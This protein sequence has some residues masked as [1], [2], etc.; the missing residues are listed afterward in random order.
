MTDRANT[1][2]LLQILREYSDPEHIL[3]MGE[4]IAKLRTTYDINIDRRTVYSS[5][6]LLQTLGYDISTYA[7]NGRGYFLRTREFEPSEIQLLIDAVCS[8]PFISA[9]QSEQLLQKLQNFRS[10][11]ERRNI[12]N[13]TAIRHT[14]KTENRQVFLNIEL[15]D[16]AIE[17]QQ[18]VSFTYLTY[19]AEKQLIPR[20]QSPYVVTPYGM[21]YTNAH[22][23]LAC[24]LDGYTNISLYR[25]DRMC[26]L[27]IIDQP[28]RAQENP[29][30]SVFHAT[31]A[32][33]GTPERIELYCEKGILNDVIDQFGS[34]ISIIEENLRYRICF[35]APPK[36]MK[37][38]ALQY[39]PYVE[40]KRPEWLREEIIKSIRENPYGI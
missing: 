14:P 6:E 27:C 29:T 34:D 3:P 7:E 18:K 25:I 17:N 2:C 39:L 36:G 26:D 20:R 19:N 40:V 8:F 12:R 33:S 13:L 37:F 10:K 28:A 9:A 15:L 1:I 24:A 30:D 35:T 4:I 22:Y 11:Y 16:E 5:I 21:L 38:W 32:F 23:Y 31:Y